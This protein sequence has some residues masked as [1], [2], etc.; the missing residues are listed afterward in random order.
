MA[1][2]EEKLKAEALQ[3]EIDDEGDGVK[4]L[5]EELAALKAKIAAASIAKL[6]QGPSQ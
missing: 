6:K 2:Y 3:A 5:R 4:A 1:D